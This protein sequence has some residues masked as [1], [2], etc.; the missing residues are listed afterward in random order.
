MRIVE[1]KSL[2]RGYA[3]IVVDLKKSVYFSGIRIYP[4]IHLTGHEPRDDEKN[5]FLPE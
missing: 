1:E 3:R 5:H 2:L 4:A